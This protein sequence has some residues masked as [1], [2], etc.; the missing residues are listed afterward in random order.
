M[1]VAMVTASA[2]MPQLSESLDEGKLG[3][4][5]DLWRNELTQSE[6]RRSRAKLSRAAAPVSC[7]KVRR[8]GRGQAGAWARAVCEPRA[9]TLK[10][11]DLTFIQRQARTVGHL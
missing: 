7:N 2:G 6:L 9:D 1:H 11:A 8:S 4:I 10:D 3:A 5:L